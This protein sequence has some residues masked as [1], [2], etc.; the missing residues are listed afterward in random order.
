[1]MLLIVG[2]VLFLGVHLLPTNP[3]LRTALAGRLGAN[4]YKVLFSVLSLAG[5]VVIV[6]GYHKMQLHQGKNPVLWDPPLWM[7]HVTIALMLPSLVLF[8]A[9]MIPSRIRDAVKHPQVLGLKLW[10][11]AH[12][13]SNGDT[14]SLLL[15]G[16]FLAYGVYELSSAKRRGAR[17]PLGEAHPKSILNDVAVVAVA[18]VVYFGLL[19]GG[20][21]W[22]IGVSPLG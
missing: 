22:L 3:E 8:V 12:L 5:L 18:L 16:S 6:M 20:H 14:A 2:L 9:S 17:G 1:M 4:A 21:L 13:L 10:A 15:F 7:R 11:F 19:H